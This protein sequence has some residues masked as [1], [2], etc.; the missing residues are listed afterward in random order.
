MSWKSILSNLLTEQQIK[1]LKVDLRVAN[2]WD[3]STKKT[4]EVLTFWKQP[5]SED[6][7]KWF[8]DNIKKRRDLEQFTDI[9]D[10]LSKRI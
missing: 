1:K 9:I 7:K 5:F 8:K 3:W 4:V 6:F 2:E 10:E